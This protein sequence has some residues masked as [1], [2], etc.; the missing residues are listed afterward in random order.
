[1]IRPLS[2]D[3]RPCNAAAVEPATAP[4]PVVRIEKLNHTFGSGEVSQQVLFD[5]DLMVKAGELVIVT[6][7]SGCGKTTLLTLIGA[8]RSVQRG[9]VQVLGQELRGLSRQA[10]IALRR[11]VGFIFQAHNLL[12]A[13]SAW[14][15]VNLALDLKAED[16]PLYERGREL[17]ELLQPD[18]SAR[19]SL[20]GTSGSRPAVARAMAS[21]ILSLLGLGDR[22]DH[23]PAALSGGQKQRVAIAR[24]LVNKPRLILADEPTAAL[25]ARSG[26]LVITMLKRLARS[27]T[28]ILVVTHDPRVMAAGDRVITLKEGRIASDARVDQTTSLSLFLR[29]VPLFSG[30]APSRLVELAEKLRPER[31]PA[32][33]EILRQGED[34][35]TLFL[36]GEGAVDV[37]LDE[38]EPSQAHLATLKA[39]QFFGELAVVEERPHT[40]TVVAAEPVQL[41]S[42]HK[43]DFR[44]ALS[45]SDSM[46]EELLKVFSQRYRNGRLSRPLEPSGR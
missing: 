12:E 31:H 39:G 22:L 2:R 7:A 6:G 23:L 37:F 32:G 34:G 10:L 35:E 25:D 36:I 42:L 3:V 19:P 43:D 5:L 41:Y 24:A 33:V 46:Q 1:M 29:K 13:L 38:G 9:S 17:F 8:L 14:R 28:A 45:S 16:G 26:E 4:A 44:N 15:N 21:G 20:E 40:A 27:G 11:N 30:L 18:A